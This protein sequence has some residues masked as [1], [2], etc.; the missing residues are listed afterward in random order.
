MVTKLLTA[1]G[2]AIALPVVLAGHATAAQP[3]NVAFHVELNKASGAEGPS[4]NP[5]AS[6]GPGHFLGQD[7]SVCLLVIH[8]DNPCGITL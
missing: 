4:G 8:P 5:K 3:P 6:S 1:M 2:I 7:T